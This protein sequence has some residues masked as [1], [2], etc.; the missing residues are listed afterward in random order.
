MTHSL[1][2]F[3]LPSWRIISEA[4]YPYAYFTSASV[5]QNTTFVIIFAVFAVHVVDVLDITASAVKHTCKENSR[6]ISII[7][8][9]SYADLATF[10][11][12]NREQLAVLTFTYLVTL[13]YWT[14]FFLCN[15]LI[16]LVHAFGPCSKS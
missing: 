3:T 15:S 4:E 1:L 5:D 2:H 9:D 11:Y 10:Y 16:N 7:F 6:P 8:N 13:R 14:R 12:H